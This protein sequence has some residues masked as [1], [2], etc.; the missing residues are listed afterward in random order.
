VLV[1]HRQGSVAKSHWPAAVGPVWSS[2]GRGRRQP[3]RD[4]CGVARLAR[5]RFA[6]GTGISWSAVGLLLAVMA[7][8][9]AHAEDAAVRTR[10][11]FDEH[12][13]RC[14]QSGRLENPP[15]KGH[16]G[17]ILNLERLIERDD[18]I[19]ASDPDASRLY[20]ILLA[21]HRPLTAFFGPIPGPTAADIGVV[22]EWIAG[23]PA[24]AIP[25]R[26]KPPV[27]RADLQRD[28]AAWRKAFEPKSDT[29]LRFVSLA[30][31]HNLCRSDAMMAAYRD[32]VGA[33][34]SRLTLKS[35]VALDTVGDASVLLAF[36]PSD[37]GLTAEAWDLRAGEGHE[38]ASVVDADALA[39][40]AIAATS[41]FAVAG[42]GAAI[43]QAVAAPA[44]IAATAGLIDGIDAVEALALEY[45]RPVSFGRAAVEM[46]IDE[47]ALRSRLAGVT[48]S[49]A[50]LALQ[51]TASV[52][53]RP[54][55]EQLRAILE[56]RSVAKDTTA[57]PTI[58]PDGLRIALWTD[59]TA[60]RTGD[61]LS[62]RARPNGD[63]NLTLIAVESDGLATVLFPN[64]TTLDNRVAKGMTV[65]LPPPSAPFQLRL[66][67]PGRHAVIAVCNATAK[68]PQG[69]GHD[70]ERQRFTVLGDWRTFLAETALREAA[71][72]KTQDELRKFRTGAGNAEKLD[73]QLPIGSEEEARAAVSF[74]V[75]P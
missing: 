50:E 58:G 11:I 44:P 18:L 15:A 34:L 59:A 73:D 63:C 37:L 61:L 46:A 55:W 56:G 75:Q 25:C 1:A 39:A 54:E 4:E 68:R 27:T 21:R 40:R 69:I 36:R 10:A 13:A 23:L 32:A 16:L 51:L 35:N 12:C 14:H 3:A 67:K 38:I 17:N 22:R 49:D 26:E 62:V 70:F 7:A 9:S 72:Q 48:G 53:P 66:D 31:L 47:A 52:L 64:D 29:P 45:T 33:L 20:Q 65:Q 57:I 5:K 30:N 71:Y 24:R 19:A 74:S 41:S 2:R 43:G 6:Y 28:I 8:E 42:G 60:Y